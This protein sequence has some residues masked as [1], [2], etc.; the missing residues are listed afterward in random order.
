MTTSPALHWNCRVQVR[1]YV[2]SINLIRSM[3]KGTERCN[4]QLLPLCFSS[5]FR[6]HS[7]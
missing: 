4:S 5:S 1:D 7:M 2:T 3:T 6:S